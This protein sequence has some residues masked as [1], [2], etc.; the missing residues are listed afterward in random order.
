MP[1]MR[2][3]WR[4]ARDPDRSTLSFVPSDCRRCA[5]STSSSRTI[6][7]S[8]LTSPISR[9]AGETAPAW[10][11]AANEVAV[12]AFLN[13]L[14]AWT[15]IADVLSAALDR[16]PGSVAD[17]VEAVLEADAAARDCARAIIERRAA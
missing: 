10:L 8:C 2:L 17:S 12:E 1:D 6:T 14:M 9:R 7:L 11:S 15:S 3:A 13:G 16:W 5:V 4:R